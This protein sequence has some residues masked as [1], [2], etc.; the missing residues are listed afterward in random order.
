[1][2]DRETAQGFS[3]ELK[4]D[5]FTIYREYLQTLFLKYFYNQKGSEKFYFKGGT[6]IR[7]LLGS[8]R[9]SEDLDFTSLL[10]EREIN[11]LISQ[12]I[13][14]LSKEATAEFKREESHEDSFTGRLF[15]NLPYFT[16]PLTVRLDIS[17]REKPFKT[18]TNYVKTIFPISPYPLVNHLSIE[19]IMA[20]KIRALIIR[21][22][23][24]DIFD[25]WFLLTK[26]VPMNWGLVNKKMSLYKRKIDSEELISVIKEMSEK[27]IKIDLTKFLPLSHRSMV[28]K[29]KELTLSE[30]KSISIY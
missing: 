24:R 23:G 14:T 9:F 12:T 11:S 1:M 25:L 18:D 26:K 16:F 27:E 29:I 13:K 8:F 4:I 10:D 28:S 22:K 2:L 15:Q 5:I 17:F 21:G 3:K 7:F 6:A 20:E 30:L 19:E